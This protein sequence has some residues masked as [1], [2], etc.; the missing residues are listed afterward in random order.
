MKKIVLSLGLISFPALAVTYEYP[1]LYKDPRAMG[2][3]GA[4]IA[5]GGTASSVFITLLA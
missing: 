2:M 4:Y 1:Y 5:V 3:G